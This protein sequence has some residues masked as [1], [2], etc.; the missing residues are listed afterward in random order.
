[1]LCRDDSVCWKVV[2]CGI[3]NAEANSMNLKALK[4]EA[5][6]G[7]QSLGKKTY[8]ANVHRNFETRSV[9]PEVSLHEE[10]DGMTVKAPC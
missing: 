8:A 3:P 10:E 2:F 4:A 5:L 7:F 9:Q 1:M 6:D